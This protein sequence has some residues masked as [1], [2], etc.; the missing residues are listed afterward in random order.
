[1]CDISYNN[2]WTKIQ[3]VVNHYDPSGGLEEYDSSGSNFD[4]S[5]SLLPLVIDPSVNIQYGSLAASGD[6][7][8][9]KIRIGQ[10]SSTTDGP[11]H[12]TYLYTLF[13]L[14]DVENGYFKS[15]ILDNDDEASFTVISQKL[16]HF[17]GPTRGY[18]DVSQNSFELIE[19][20]SSLNLNWG[21]LDISGAGGGVK[22][23]LKDSNNPSFMVSNIKY[24]NL[25]ASNKTSMKDDILYAQTKILDISEHITN[26]EALTM[27]TNKYD[28]LGISESAINKS[29]QEIAAF[30]ADALKRWLRGHPDAQAPPVGTRET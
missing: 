10:K 28:A 17:N 16:G 2:Q 8:C 27:S 11:T 18:P 29:G 24:L 26:K 5:A 21:Y 4:S 1:M 6:W 22:N 25:F 12:N 3:F 30:E 15:N 20:D 7:F 19:M 13:G 14:E 23:F 9:K